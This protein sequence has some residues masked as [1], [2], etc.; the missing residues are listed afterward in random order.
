MINSKDVRQGNIGS[1]YFLTGIVSFVE[2]YPEQI[3][4]LF[5]MKKNPSH[6]YG[7]RLF[8]EGKW[9][10]FMLDA[11]F[12]LGKYDTFCCAKP[13]YREIWVMLLE[14]AWAKAYGSY[15]AIDGGQNDEG[16]TAISGAPASMFF[17]HQ[18][19]LIETI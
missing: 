6:L 12:P 15:D 10:I 5:V 17:T 9:R 11:S 14:K 7:V 4:K 19:R 13:H 1:C 18:K 16:L 3:F 2:Q 8:I